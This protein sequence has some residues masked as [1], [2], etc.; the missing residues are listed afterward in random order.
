MRKKIN[1]DDEIL[2][3][4]DVAKLLKISQSLVYKL[5]SNGDIPHR[6]PNGNDPRYIKRE[7][8]DWFNR[9]EAS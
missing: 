1:S 3:A 5:T 7:V 8:L 2:K 4:K 6:R 9:Q